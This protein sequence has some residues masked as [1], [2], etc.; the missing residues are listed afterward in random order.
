MPLMQTKEKKDNKQILLDLI[1]KQYGLSNAVVMEK[2]LKTQDKQIEQAMMEGGATADKIGQTKGID[3]SLL[4]KL[5][6]N[7][8]SVKATGEVKPQ[9]QQPQPQA[10]PQTQPQGNNMLSRLMMSIG[11]GL[12]SA[13]GQQGIAPAL[14]SLIAQRE[15]MQQASQG[16]GF[17]KFDP[18]TGQ[19]EQVATLP[20]GSEVRN[21]QFSPQE[22]GEV[23]VDVAK[24]KEELKRESGE[25]VQMATSLDQMDILLGDMEG[26][27]QQNPLAFVKGINPLAERE[28]KAILQNFDKTAAIAAGGKQLT[29]TE[30]DLIRNTRPTILDTK[31]PKAIQYKFNIL[32]NTIAM[33][34]DRL[35]KGTRYEEQKPNEDKW[36]KFLSITG[37]SK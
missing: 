12:A 7:Q 20:K 3:L 22:R 2:A 34:R 31:N 28:F 25:R 19:L 6:Q 4:D 26:Y 16:M 1:E 37:R 14:L 29:K 5:I 30:L 8:G 13:G 17:Y 33:A 9:V 36:K 15:K 18:T 32:K 27:L 24:Q 21:R 23:A 35:N 11:S 10:Q